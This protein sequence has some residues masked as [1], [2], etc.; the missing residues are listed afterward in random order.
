MSEYD[1]L[2]VEIK[3]G[4]GYLGMNR[5]E[6]RNALNYGLLGELVSAAEEMDKNE[7]VGVIVLY[8]CID[9]VFCAGADIKER[10]VMTDEQV[11]AR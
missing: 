9:N 10:R 7:E 3:N 5:Y 1:F 6:A 2:N 8:S 4:V 11:T